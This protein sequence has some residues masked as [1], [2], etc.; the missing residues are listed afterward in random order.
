MSASLSGIYEYWLQ[1]PDLLH[2]VEHSSVRNLV[3]TVDSPIALQDRQHALLNEALITPILRRMADCR[4]LLVNGVDDFVIQIIVFC[5]RVYGQSG[6]ITEDTAL[7]VE[8]QD[9]DMEVVRVLA[10]GVKRC[11][12]YIRKTFVRQ[13]MPQDCPPVSVILNALKVQ[14]LKSPACRTQRWPKC[15]QFLV[16][17]NL[18]MLMA[19]QP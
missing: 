17:P 3:K 6:D 7:E 11:V 8:I 13:H 5:A 9:G 19:M 12:A 15:W 16:I 14:R 1:D 10:M 18:R 4:T 2:R